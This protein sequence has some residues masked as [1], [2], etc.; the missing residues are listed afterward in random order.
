MAI[1]I[2]FPR[3]K[4]QPPIVQTP[5]THKTA[6]IVDSSSELSRGRKVTQHSSENSTTAEIIAE[7][8][9]L[10]GLTTVKR[11]IYEIQAYIDI[12]K[13]RTR[14]K[15]AAEPLVL[16]MIFRGNPGTGKTTVARL[17]GRL[18][19]E[20]NVLQKGH[21]IECERADLVGEYIGHT[22]QKTR[23]MVK[24]ALGGILFIDEA[25]SLARGGEKDFGKEA[26]DALVK[27]MEDHKNDLI[28][29]LAGYKHEMEWFLQTNP[30]LRSRFPIHIDFPDYAIEELLSIGDSMLKTRQYQ[31]TSDARDAFRFM[32]QGV[33]N[34]HPYAGNARLVRNMV[35]KAIR[36]QAVRLYEKSTSSREELMGILPCDLSLEDED[37][38]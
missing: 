10:V 2:T 31:F 14:E 20:M 38:K 9:A 6:A 23:D 5:R 34:S 25:Y 33:L 15:L 1:R 36:K 4:N 26:I 19:K 29:I 21:I 37:L 3:E 8:N 30:G 27:A 11:L 12:Q 13:R 28:L 35:E 7:L 32:L 17:I 24:K 16:H 18:F 22:A